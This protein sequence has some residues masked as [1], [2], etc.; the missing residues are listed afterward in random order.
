MLSNL[1]VSKCLVAF[2]RQYSQS[3]GLEGFVEFTSKTSKMKFYRD[4]GAVSTY[5]QNMMITDDVALDLT[6][7]YFSGGVKWWD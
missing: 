1:G 7:Q 3:K 6:N 5:G 2:A 4:L